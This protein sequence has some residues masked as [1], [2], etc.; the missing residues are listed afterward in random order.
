MS[1]RTDMC[2]FILVRWGDRNRPTYNM[3]R[4]WRPG[5]TGMKRPCWSCHATISAIHM[6][7]CVRNCRGLVLH[8][9]KFSYNPLKY[10]NKNSDLCLF[11][12]SWHFSKRFQDNIDQQYSWFQRVV[13][14]VFSDSPQGTVGKIIATPWKFRGIFPVISSTVSFFEKWFG[15]HCFLSGHYSQIIQCCFNLWHAG[16]NSTN[17]AESSPD[18]SNMMKITAYAYILF[19]MCPISRHEWN[20]LYI[21]ISTSYNIWCCIFGRMVT[22]WRLSLYRCARKVDCK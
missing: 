16:Y 22:C 21:K 12:R 10:N 6:R 18:I 2:V 9:K 7:I 15:I 4:Y 14:P 19:Q 1:S 5:S 8:N 11:S 13:G 17:G 20:I 3:A